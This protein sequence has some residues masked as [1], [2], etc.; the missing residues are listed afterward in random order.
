MQK[1][2]EGIMDNTYQTLIIIDRL[3]DICIR[4]Y[5]CLNKAAEAFK[6]M[7]L[8]K[9]LNSNAYSLGFNLLRRLCEFLNISYQYA[10]FGGKEEPLSVTEYTYKNFYNEYKRIYKDNVGHAVYQSYWKHRMPLKHLINLAQ[11]TGKT[12]DYLIGG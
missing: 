9:Y 6:D 1:T 5:G 11:R 12:I 8:N 10:V 4:R 2:L 3:R 7:N